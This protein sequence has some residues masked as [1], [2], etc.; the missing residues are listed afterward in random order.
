MLSTNSKFSEIIQSIRNK[1]FQHGLVVK[2]Y[3]PTNG[4]V[5]NYYF[6]IIKATRPFYNR[7][8]DLKFMI[9]RPSDDKIKNFKRK[10][11][12]FMQ[13]R[14]NKS[15]EITF[16]TLLWH[17]IGERKFYYGRDVLN[18]QT[19]KDAII[20]DRKPPENLIFLEDDEMLLLI[21]PSKFG[22]TAWNRF[23]NKYSRGGY[24]N[25]I[26]EIVRCMRPIEDILKIDKL[27][28]SGVVITI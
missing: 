6:K 26:R 14:D 13:S 27:N 20:L 18:T 9:S 25:E 21:A 2:S 1:N 28:L 11:D 19:I 12:L 7:F 5:T 10:P 22:T 4:V 15:K 16:D 24:D 23:L 8:V 3:I 17:H